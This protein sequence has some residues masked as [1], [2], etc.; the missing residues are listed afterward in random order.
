MLVAAGLIK[1]PADLYTLQIKDLLPLERMAQKSAENL[2][3]G[4][5]SSK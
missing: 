2:I 5:Q 3:K 4:V 1:D